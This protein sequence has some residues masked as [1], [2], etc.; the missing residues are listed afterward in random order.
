M[1]FRTDDAERTVFLV[2]AVLWDLC[3]SVILIIGSRIDNVPNTQPM[4][5]TM[6]T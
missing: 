1:V 3:F 5:A 6:C 4:V 2:G